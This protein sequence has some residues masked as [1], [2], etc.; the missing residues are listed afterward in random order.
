[1]NSPSPSQ[2]NSIKNAHGVQ[3]QLESFSRRPSAC[4]P[5]PL[6]PS[7]PPH[8]CCMMYQSW[9]TDKDA[10]ACSSTPW[11]RTGQE[12]LDQQSQDILSLV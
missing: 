9:N 2:E 12:E 7:P 4:P 3:A 6:L 11:E 5:P 1:M 8:R 10:G